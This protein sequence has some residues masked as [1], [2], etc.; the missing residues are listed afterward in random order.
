MV[1]P[2]EW[3]GL[4]QRPPTLYELLSLDPS[5][6][7]A[8][9]IRSAADKQFRRILPHLTG[10]N[11]LDAE[12]IWNE[13]E[14]ARDTL[15][16]PDRRTHYDATLPAEGIQANSEA[17]PASQPAPGEPVAES[18]L[19]PDELA[20]ASLPDP[21]PWW[22]TTPEA[23]TGP[24]PW[25]K[26]SA[27]D[28]PAPPPPAPGVAAIADRPMTIPREKLDESSRNRTSIVLTGVGLIAVVAI[29]GGIYFGAFK[30]R[31]T[32]TAVF[33][34]AVEGPKVDPK[35]KLPT[36]GTTR[37]DL[38]TRE[39]PKEP[40]HPS[41]T[42]PRIRPE[43]FAGPAAKPPATP[44]P[45]P[46]ADA[47][48]NAM[49]AIQKELERE[50][51]LDQPDE[52]AILAEN[53]RRRAS[54]ERVSTAQR[55]GLLQEARTIATRVGEAKIAFQCVDDLAAWFDVD[56]LAEKTSTFE[57]LATKLAPANLVAVGISLAERAESEVRPEIVER[58]HKRLFAIP[59]ADFPADRKT[60]FS[61]LR[62]RITARAA[63]Q[64][65]V[66]QALA[67]LKNA[68]D[69]QASNEVVG[70]YLCLAHQD[71][72]S[73]LPYLSNGKGQKSVEA[74]KIDLSTPRDPKAQLNLGE[75]WFGLAVDEKENRAKRALLARARSWF[76]RAAMSKL[77]ADEMEKI[78]ARLGE[79]AKLEVPSTDPGTLPLL[80]PFQ[81]R[82]A[83]NT[84]G[85]EVRAQEWRIIGGESQGEGVLLPEGSPVLTSR[86]GLGTGGRLT[87]ALHPD[88]REVRVNCAGQEFAFSGEGKSLRIAIERSEHR[89]TLTASSDQ[90]EPVS[91]SAEL[92]G[93]MR[94]QLNI[95]FRLTG[96][97]VRAGGVLI[98]S[99][100]VRGPM[101]IPLPLVE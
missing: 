38:S 78:R 97:S 39:S 31:S 26:E 60:E 80:A 64:K 57:Y 71:W 79:I 69:D 74:A 41:V 66:H 96:T 33:V 50:F 85:P 86:F 29:A 55:Y 47:V 40:T 59:S 61:A 72:T 51:N 23:P 77:G 13:L 95:T 10:P 11:A 8:A 49:T 32:T 53:L 12:R 88:G 84:L 3:L 76:E 101:S 36:A 44:L 14:D 43:V 30:G 18:P 89:V 42:E 1:D 22:K 20:A 93:T 5:V 2:Y 82:R 28:K 99:A 24:Q 94:G 81:V 90:G 19:S 46:D 56:D 4:S 67:V 75:M 7:D 73:G 6:A 87:L 98:Y 37:P 58:V 52:R 27:P 17:G 45:I 92:P 62:Q 16:D 9:V 25:W 63:E 48:T 35:P 100:I 34:P 21:N 15:L 54:L 70:N 65:K 83:Y 68:P 91:R